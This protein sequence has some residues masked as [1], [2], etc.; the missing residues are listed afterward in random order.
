MRTMIMIV[1]ALGLASCGGN[2]APTAAANNQAM[3]ET[4]AAAQV[5]Q[6]DEAQRNGVLER[7]IRAS[8]A[9]CPVVSE[10]VRTEVRK[11]VMGWKAQCDN[12]SAHLIEITSDG[13]GRVTSRRD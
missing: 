13:T 12:D 9:A 10:S 5:A 6:L 4:G 8:G 7:A 11:G 1:A 3:P 2:D